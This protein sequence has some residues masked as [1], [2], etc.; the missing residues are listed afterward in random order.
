MIREFETAR[1]DLVK[2]DKVRIDDYRFGRNQ[3]GARDVWIESGEKGERFLSR[4]TVQGQPFAVR[5]EI[6]ASKCYILR[7][8]STGRY[9][10]LDVNDCGFWLHS[11][12]FSGAETFSGD[13]SRKI[14]Q[15]LR[16]FAH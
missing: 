11:E 4:I 15:W 10:F 6:Y 9:W 12:R 16:S 14:R 7:E 13:E 3:K 2:G 8:K 5:T 1:F